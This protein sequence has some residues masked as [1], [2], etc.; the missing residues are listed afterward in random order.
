M[1]VHTEQAPAVV[2]HAEVIDHEPASVRFVDMDFRG[3]PPERLLPYLQTISLRLHGNGPTIN[4]V[5]PREF[6]RLGNGFRLG[7]HV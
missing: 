1:V 2:T 4:E 5:L 7:M 6:E 3:T